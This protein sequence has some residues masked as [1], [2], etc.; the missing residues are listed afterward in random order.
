[1][2]FSKGVHGQKQEIKQKVRDSLWSMGMK[3]QPL[4]PAVPNVCST[5]FFDRFLLAEKNTRN[6]KNRHFDWQR[7]LHDPFACES[8]L[9]SSYSGTIL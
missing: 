6:Q 2:G 8:G 5:M 1:M 9:Y 3:K 4:A 7:D